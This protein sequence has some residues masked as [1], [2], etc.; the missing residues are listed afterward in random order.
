[1]KLWMIIMVGWVIYKAFYPD[2]EV[3]PQTQPQQTK[4]RKTR[5]KHT[6]LLTYYVPASPTTRRRIEKHP[7][8]S[9]KATVRQKGMFPEHFIINNTTETDYE[10]V[11]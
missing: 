6:M 2:Q 11:S 10:E 8:I 5:K 4:K 9:E 1:M 3:I 7:R